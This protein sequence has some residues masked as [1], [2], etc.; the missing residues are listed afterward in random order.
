[1]KTK[2]FATLPTNSVFPPRNPGSTQDL[3][4]PKALEKAM[5]VQMA[6]QAAADAKNRHIAFL[7]HEIRN[8]VN[9]ILASV[10]AIEDLVHLPG[11][12]SECGS[13]TDGDG[14]ADGC[15]TQ[16]QDLV[17]TTLAC[18]AQ[19]QRTVD[20]ILDLRQMEGKLEVKAASFRVSNVL[21]TV[22]NQVSSA[23]S[24]NPTCTQLCIVDMCI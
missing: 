3:T 22:L 14:K 20:G 18:T 24:Q 9:G 23:S 10:Q 16:I 8:P 7:C 15:Y 4:L 2:R 21:Q 1:M 11:L 13:D 19:L 5:A 17:R 6:A 12:D